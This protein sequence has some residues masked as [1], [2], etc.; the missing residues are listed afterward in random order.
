[1]A[2]SATI[3]VIGT[4]SASPRIHRL[5]YEVGRELGIRG[6]TLVCGGLGG[7]MEAAAQG[8]YEAGAQTVGI[9]PGYDRRAA[10]RFIRLAIVTGIGEARNLIVVASAQAVIA[11]EGEGGTLAEIGF[12]LKL[13]RPVV[14]LEAWREI[15]GLH[16]A[17]TPLAAAE[18]ALALAASPKP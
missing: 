10:N 1:M 16:H 14:A 5:A 17:Q 7:V 12:A 8:A 18:L 15:A 3:A 4:G 11:L 9:L 2:E 6:A 13:K